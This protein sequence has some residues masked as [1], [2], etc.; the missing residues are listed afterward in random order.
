MNPARWLGPAIVAHAWAF[1]WAYSLVP[2]AAALLAAGLR[3]GGS[4]THPMPHTGKLF[5]DS[6]YR[7]LFREDKLPSRLP[8]EARRDI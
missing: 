7:S 3:R 6:R 1:G 4:L 8:D 2:L 5:H